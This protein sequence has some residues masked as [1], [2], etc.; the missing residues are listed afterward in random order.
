[1]WLATSSYA[2]LTLEHF[3]EAAIIPMMWRAISV[4]PYLTPSAAAASAA[5]PAAA[6]A[7]PDGSD[8]DGA[9]R[10]PHR[11]HV[12][13]PRRRPRLGRRFHSRTRC[14]AEHPQQPPPL[15]LACASPTL[16]PAAALASAPAPNPAPA[17]TPTAAPA[18]VPATVPAPGPGPCISTGRPPPQRAHF[19]HIRLALG[20]F[21]VPAR[22]GLREV[23]LDT[24]RIARGA[25]CAREER[26]APP[27][28]G[29]PPRHLHR[30][31]PRGRGLHS[32]TFQLNL[33][34]LYGIGGARRGCIARVKGV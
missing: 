30:R 27:R 11:P 14:P 7:A 29:R 25:S 12:L 5:A 2:F 23:K 26:G 10:A 24:W 28:A 33:S 34:A 15:P 17:L 6:A 31:R 1:M 4:S 18:S 22:R 20:R 8:A 19:L 32:S 16:T 13:R 9:T 21:A 3:S